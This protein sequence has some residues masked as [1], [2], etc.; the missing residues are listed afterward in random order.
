M[1][2]LDANAAGMAE[3]SRR[4]AASPSRGGAPNAL[5]VVAAAEQPPAELLDVAA[6]VTVQ[7]PWG[8]L[9]R[10]ALALDAAVAEGLA[11]LL[12]PGGRVAVTTSVTE[13]DGLALPSLDDPAEIACLAERWRR[14]GLEMTAI[15][16]ATS[17]EVRDTRSSWARRL[18][19]GRD[20]P[21]WRFELVA[22]TSLTPQRSSLKA[23]GRIAER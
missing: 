23:A 18:A 6:E 11:A 9:L 3:V 2:G 20:R 12:R 7:F 1:I 14:F 19:A 8:S 17:D 15:R 13:R 22:R 21:V 10:G 4:A 5:F 16:P